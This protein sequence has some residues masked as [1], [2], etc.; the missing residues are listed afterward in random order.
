MHARPLHDMRQAHIVV[1]YKVGSLKC[2]VLCTLL[3]AAIDVQV[4]HP[5]S[6]LACFC[7]VVDPKITTNLLH[8]SSSAV[9][10]GYRQ[11]I[12][13]NGVVLLGTLIF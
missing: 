12:S 1:A 2:C 5:H 13:C 8:C 10:M 9:V 6:L 4:V 7:T 3:I 11:C